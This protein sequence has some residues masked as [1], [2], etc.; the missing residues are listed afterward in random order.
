LILT[1]I[2][3]THN[4]HHQLK[5]PGGD[6]LIHAGDC[7]RNGTLSEVENF[8]QWLSV[9]PYERKVFIAGNHDMLFQ[10]RPVRSRRLLKKFPGITYLQD[11]GVTIGGLHIYGSPWTP[12]FGCWSFTL[13]RWGDNLAHKWFNIPK[14]VHVLL[15]HGPPYGI[16]DTAYNNH[17]GCEILANVLKDLKPLIHVFGHIHESPGM[18]GFYSDTLS[19]NASMVEHH[20]ER[21]TRK[22]INILITEII[23]ETC[24]ENSDVVASK[25]FTYSIIEEENKNDD[26]DLRDSGAVPQGGETS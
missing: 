25:K 6:I 9:Q 14:D 8:L 19:I 5:L 3:D 1:I 4:K 15:T 16:L 23:E 26:D 7:T 17:C 22:P 12:R 21:I 24:Q 18:V 10:Q 13:D 11:S 2:S 20:S